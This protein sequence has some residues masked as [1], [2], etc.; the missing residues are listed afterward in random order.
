MTEGSAPLSYLQCQEATAARHSPSQ[1]GN[2][3]QSTYCPI[4]QEPW[5][6]VGAPNTCSTV[7][8]SSSSSRS[9]A[10]VASVTSI[11]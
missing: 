7:S 4:S 11:P 5:S 6:Y 1:D 9:C 10:R 3:V 8:I 2:R